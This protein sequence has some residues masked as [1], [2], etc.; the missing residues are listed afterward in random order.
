MDMITYMRYIYWRWCFVC[1]VS[2]EWI[3]K[4][5]YGTITYNKRGNLF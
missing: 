4:C 3:S 5:L 2:A 1:F